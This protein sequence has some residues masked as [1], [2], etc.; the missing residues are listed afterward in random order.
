MKVK[1]SEIPQEGL[2]VTERFDPT[3]L[4]L[5]TPDL[6]FVGPPTVTARF[7]KEKET[8]WVQV[9]VTGDQ[10]QVCSRCLGLVDQHYQREFLL[11]YSVEER[12]VLDVT[13]D[14]RQ[15]IFLSY[16]VKFLC[17]EDCRGLCPVCGENLNERSCPHGTS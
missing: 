1:A 11:G 13:D 15:E 14:I 7:Q 4:G 2:T 10:K 17:R 3:G 6:R 5:D 16:P 8:V 9:D 12:L